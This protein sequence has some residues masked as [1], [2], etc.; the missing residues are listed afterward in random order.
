MRHLERLNDYYNWQQWNVTSL[1][2]IAD[3]FGVLK[4]RQFVNARLIVRKH[5]HWFFMSEYYQ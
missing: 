3:I 1:L 5:V 2:I 4:V